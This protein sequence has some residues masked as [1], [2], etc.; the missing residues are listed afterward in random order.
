M[1][2]TS[3]LTSPI[4][5]AGEVSAESVAMRP[6]GVQRMVEIFERQQAEGLHPGAQLVVL[7]Q[8]QVVLDRVV[9]LAD[10]RRKR[11]VTPDT[12]FL[13]FSVT[14]A[15]T[16]M[17]IHKLIEEGKVE[18]DAPVAEY[19]PEFGCKGKETA[20]IRH[21]FLHQAGVATRGMTRQVPLWLNWNALMGSIAAL[22][23]E[24]P[25]GSKT[26]YHVVNYGFIF[27]EVVRRV[28]GIPIVEFMRQTFIEPLGMDN[29]WLRL[30][31]RQLSRVS[32]IYSANPD[33]RSLARLF[34]VPI[35]RRAVVP[36][37]S[38]NSTARDMAVFYQML[39][40]GGQYA[41]RRYVQPETIAA[42]TALGFHGIDHFSQQETF[43]AHGFHLGGRTPSPGE[44]G[45][46]FGRASSLRTFGHAGNGTCI[47]WADP[48]AEMVLAFTCNLI[49]PQRET[50]IRWQSLADAL[51][52]ALDP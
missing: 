46:S 52:E 22:E 7:R 28:T 12:P 39:L 4:K 17:C 10:L 8:G 34:S 36:A 3:T 2:P 47:A 42:A 37:A 26:S 20:T 13:T 6:D 15:L 29:T 41:G 50:A 48:E 25:P 18:W 33:Q 9:G 27:G 1:P 14:K 40:N 19:W 43:W 44:P 5:F 30:P 24:Y 49:L 23:T 38:L 51:W 16:G 35:Y 45:P 31:R 11:P 32:R 21:V